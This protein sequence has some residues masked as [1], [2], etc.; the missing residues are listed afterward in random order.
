M[1]MNSRDYPNPGEERYLRMTSGE[2]AIWAAVFAYYTA[3][4]S[5]LAK[6]VRAAGE[7]VIDLREHA[8]TTFPDG[9]ETAFLLR[10]M[11][12]RRRVSMEEEKETDSVAMWLSHNGFKKTMAA[13]NKEADLGYD[14]EADSDDGKGEG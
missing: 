9:S 10:S 12:N 4:A 8:L 1:T 3:S 13:F 6:A 5:G 7:V 14:P 11:I 2:Q